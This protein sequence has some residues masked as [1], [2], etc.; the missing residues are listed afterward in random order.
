MKE[1]R[2]RSEILEFV[3]KI[4]SWSLILSALIFLF[5]M[6]FGIVRS[7][8]ETL[9]SAVLQSGIFLELIR[10]EREIRNIEVK[11]KELDVKLNLLWEDFR[12]KKKL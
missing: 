6:L 11:S 8:S 4:V 7:P 9:I 10:I 3:W 2:E 1:K 5:L 12:K